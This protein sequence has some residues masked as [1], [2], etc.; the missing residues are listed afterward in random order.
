MKTTTKQLHRIISESIKKHLLSEESG[1][2][3]AG[4]EF[5][6]RAPYNQVS[7]DPKIEQFEREYPTYKFLVGMLSFNGEDD[8]TLLQTLRSEMNNG[9]P[10]TVKLFAEF[11]Y[12]EE[13]EE[14]DEDGYS[15]RNR[16]D[17]ELRSFDVDL[18]RSEWFNVL[19]ERN[20]RLHRMLSNNYADIKS[21][22]LDECP[23]KEVLL[24]ELKKM[25]L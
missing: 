14:P 20:P 17:E 1:L 21:W 19:K 18:Y 2:Y 4:A 13:M 24:E 12:Y 25:G 5:D 7:S 22:L 8:I 9:A 23:N 11:S 6:S 10:E 3:P 15:F 16:V